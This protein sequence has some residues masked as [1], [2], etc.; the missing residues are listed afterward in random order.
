MIHSEST[1]LSKLGSNLLWHKKI[2]HYKYVICRTK[3][4]M[5][6]RTWVHDLLFFI[7]LTMY[8]SKWNSV[9]HLHLHSS[10]IYYSF[11][12]YRQSRCK[13]I[14]IYDINFNSVSFLFSFFI[15]LLS[16]FIHSFISHK[17]SYKNNQSI[18]FDLDLSRFSVKSGLQTHIHAQ[19]NIFRICQQND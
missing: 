2:A 5:A 7:S 16:I 13:W 10:L 12:V 17:K 6:L 4:T 11:A 18:W 1:V 8:F 9:N 3:H 15:E 14:I 19:W